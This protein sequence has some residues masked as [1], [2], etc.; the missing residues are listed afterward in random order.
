LRLTA[1][2]A[3]TTA[4]ANVAI[5]SREVTSEAKCTCQIYR[6]V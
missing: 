5:K 1:I 6:Q 4:K 2:R 3:P